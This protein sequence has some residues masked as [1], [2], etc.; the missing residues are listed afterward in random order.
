[1]TFLL[2][3]LFVKFSPLSS[4]AGIFADWECLLNERLRRLRSHVQR[5]M[6]ASRAGS[7]G[8]R[9]LAMRFVN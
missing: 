7:P 8:R 3:R 4:D 2:P 1:M 6:T 5:T 9:A